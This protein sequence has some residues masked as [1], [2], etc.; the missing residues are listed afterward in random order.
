MRE[1]IAATGLAAAS[2]GKLRMYV[3]GKYPDNGSTKDRP[4]VEEPRGCFFDGFAQRKKLRHA[5]DVFRAFH[6]SKFVRRSVADLTKNDLVVVQHGEPEGQPFLVVSEDFVTDQRHRQH[7]PQTGTIDCLRLPQLG[8]RI[9]S[10]IGSARL[11]DAA[12]L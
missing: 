10:S 9:N 6:P 8:F 5:R 3:P 11:V 4:L 1:L 12:G 7:F 2:L